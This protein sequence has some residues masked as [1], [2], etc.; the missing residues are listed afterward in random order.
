ME[1]A[2]HG[3]TYIYSHKLN[4]SHKVGGRVSIYY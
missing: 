1:I 3:V 4:K 2:I